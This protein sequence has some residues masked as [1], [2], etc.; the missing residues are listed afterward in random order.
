MSYNHFQLSILF[1]FFFIVSCSKP[2]T[3]DSLSDVLLGF[4]VI[5]DSARTKTWWFH[6][7]TET[8]KEGITADLEA[9]KNAGVGGV[10]YY[11]QSHGDA[12]DA[13]PGFSP[14]W[15][16]MLR[17]SAEEAERI[18]LSF[19]MNI[20]NGF[21]AGGVWIPDSLSMKRLAATETIVLGNRKIKEKLQKPTNKYD[22]SKDVAVLAFPIPMES[23]STLTHPFKVSSNLEKLDLE[24]IFDPQSNKLTLIPTNKKGESVY[25][26]LEFEEEFIARN[27]SY[28][29]RP[30]G[31][32]TTS[33]TNVPGPPQETFVGTGY[34]VL[35]DLGQLEVSNDGV[36]YQFVCDLKPIYRAH[37]NWKQKT[38][39]F[40]SVK[41]K[42]FRLNLHD[43][44]ED[45]DV[46][47]NTQLGSVVLSSS[48]KVDQWEEKAA[49][50]SEYIEQDHT[51]EYGKA[52]VI[53]LSS[54][55]DITDKLDEEGYIHWDVPKGNWKIMRFSYVL[56]GGMSKHGRKNL[57]GRECDKLSAEA[58]EFHWNS[59][60]GRVI[61]SLTVSN[62]RN[63]MGIVMDSH[64]AGSQNWTDN[65]INE[66]IER[67]G[68]DPKLFLPAMMGYVI[69]DVRTSTGFLFDVR[70]NIADMIADNYYG[71]FNQLCKKNN[72]TFTAQATGNALCIVADPIQAKSKVSKPQGEFWP[73][74]PDGNY[75]IKE[76]SSAAHLY[77]KQIASAEA[78]TD[79]KYYHSL[80][81]LK[82][83]ADYAYAFGINEFV[84]CASAYQPWIGKY[85]GN[86]GGG[87]HYCIN[88]NNTFWNYSNS[89]WD[90]QARSAYIMRKGK[91]KVD[92]CVYLG[93][94]APV[95]ILTYR[96]PDIPGGFDFDAFTSD[97]LFNR[98]SSKNGKIVLPDGVNYNIMI[99]PRNGDIT[100]DALKKIEQMIKDGITVYGSRPQ[101]S[102]SYKDIAS[103]NE[104]E[105]IVNKIWGKNTTLEGR[106]NYGKGLVLWGMSLD[107]ALR[108]SAITAD[109]EMKTGNTKENKI[110]FAHRQ[111]SDA[112]IYFIA[113]RKDSEEKNTFTFNSFGEE[114]QLWHPVTGERY[115]L[116]I[117][118]KTKEKTS[119]ELYMNPRESFF[120]II[121]KKEENL[122]F[123]NFKSVTDE[124]V[125][126]GS[127]NVFFSP[128]K[129]GPGNVVFDDLFDWTKSEV[130]GIKYYSGTAIYK[131]NIN[132]HLD[133][134]KSI[135]LDIGNPNFVA[136]VFIN[137]QDAGVIW[138]SPWSVDITKYL[139]EGNNQIEIHVANSLMNRMI[140]DASLPVN[141]RITYSYP[142]IVR[143]DDDLVASGLTQVKLIRK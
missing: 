113:N 15:W 134:D 21:V 64:E 83:L 74:Q 86:T 33:A 41:G 63:L 95:K 17:F 121:T 89:F 32:A 116:N 130:P 135:Y 40:P 136:Q 12:V 34:R 9:F 132:V 110:Y 109:V 120:I 38:I 28:E 108:Q 93:E 53:D 54:V 50:Y 94:N 5:Q 90:Y 79:A 30:R 37:E 105:D 67:R 88:R 11:D 73:L 133:N 72:L 91:S 141:Q 118:S 97:A 107:D 104:Y 20:S 106:N 140:Y 60:V 131:K 48:A 98:M 36:N 22:F 46:H 71:T 58:A 26:N 43:W 35:P 102:G 1:S 31:K 56:T 138:C 7:E 119:V 127:W 6:G 124:E 65:F 129:G 85:P 66:F 123:L 115:A 114:V 117:K 68:Y 125:I 52:E 8:T 92:L 3:T 78:Y 45:E 59:Y 61:D 139:Q 111:L 10:V 122:P 25:I 14:E 101:I 2:I 27:I 84:I 62:S 99:L 77:N 24:N 69:D 47:P 4:E 13:L 16:S 143:P 49:F 51:P 23:S 81:D 96:L 29:V 70:R 126:T 100:L 39:S 57:L 80:A 19:E 76:C 18:G 44:W 55:L 112:D 142:S 128:E 137:S 75:D 87:R 42:Y 103:T 82:S